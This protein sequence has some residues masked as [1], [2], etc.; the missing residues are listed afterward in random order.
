MEVRDG[1]CGIKH[2]SSNKMVDQLL[3]MMD[4]EC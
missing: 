1:G 3:E 4:G 2:C